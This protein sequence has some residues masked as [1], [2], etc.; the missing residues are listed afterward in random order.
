[1]PSS[2]G[3]PNERASRS[4]ADSSSP[5]SDQTTPHT[6]RRCSSSGNG[7]PGGMVR[8]AKKPLELVGLRGQEVAVP[9]EHLGRVVDVV[10]HGPA[11]HGA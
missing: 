3:V 4:A 8:N 1:M 11:M 10:Q 9:A 5:A 7:G 2:S 6:L